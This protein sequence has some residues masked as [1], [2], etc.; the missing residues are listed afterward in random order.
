[1]T[2]SSQFSALSRLAQMKEIAAGFVFNSQLQILAKET[3]D[4]YNEASLRQIAANMLSVSSRGEEMGMQIPEF[5]VRFEH[6]MV[7]TKRFGSNLDHYLVIFADRAINVDELRQPL[8]LAVLNLERAVSSVEEE[9]NRKAAQTELALRAQAAERALF[10]DTHQDTNQFVARLDILAEKFFG[11]PYVDII[12][13]ACKEC[14]LSLP[15]EKIE[16]MRKLSAQLAS[17]LKTPAKKEIFNV[18]AE[19]FI[20]RFVLSSEKQTAT[21]LKT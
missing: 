9:L 19:D 10:A 6:F 12:R 17:Y 18:Q 4:R 21:T 1:M 7:W 11:P 14:D 20:Q 5:W 15:I 2:T 13:M 3:P 8:N 16:D